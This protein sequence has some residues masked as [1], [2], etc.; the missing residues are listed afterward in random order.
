MS[1]FS[2]FSRSSRNAR[3]EWVV[4]CTDCREPICV[5]TIPIGK[6]QCELCRR[7][8]NGETLDDDTV[9]LIKASKAPITG[10]T[11]LN[12]SPQA[13]QLDQVKTMGNG[14]LKAL[15]RL[16]GREVTQ[17]EEVVLEKSRKRLFDDVDLETALGTDESGQRV[18]GSMQEIDAMFDKEN[19]K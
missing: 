3:G 15:G 11:A 16:V 18:F 4:Y 19:Q 7:V 17:A 13:D 9:K 2:A 5:T 10:V 14:F 8:A 12:L 6:M 1:V